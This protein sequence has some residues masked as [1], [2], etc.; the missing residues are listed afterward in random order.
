MPKLPTPQRG[1]PLDVSYVSS[2]VEAVNDI[3]SKTANTA[4]NNT[5]ISTAS[6]QTK[7]S[8]AIINSAIWGFTERVA[9]AATVTAG[10]EFPFSVNFNCKYTPVV[11]ATPWNVSGTDAGK[12][13]SVY[14]SS[15]T[16]TSATLVAKF[17]SN[18]IATLDVNVLVIGIPPQS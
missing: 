18:G 8:A 4:N 14:I 9:N 1:Q 16:N 15:V 10:Q 2:I 7:N 11:V 5:T 17:T 6:T 13:A 12:N 3:Y